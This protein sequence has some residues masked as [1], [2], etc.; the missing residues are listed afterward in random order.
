MIL[1][2]TKGYPELIL[3]TACDTPLFYK[4]AEWLQEKFDISFIKK[5]DSSQ[6]IV[7]EFLFDKSLMALKYDLLNGLFICPVALNQLT[8]EDRQAFNKLV[9]KLTDN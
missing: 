6:D 1:Q 4:I 7:W 5:I 2:L 3:M 9:E 8:G